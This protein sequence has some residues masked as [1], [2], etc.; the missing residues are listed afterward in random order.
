MSLQRVFALVMRYLYL[1][2]S[3]W[4]RLIELIYWPTMQMILWGF[5]N[6]F[7]V[8][9]SEWVAQAAGLLIGAVLLWD[10]LFRAQLGVSVV[11]FEEMYSRNLGHLF[12]SPL[13]PYELVMALLTV[14]FLRTSIGVGAA[15]GLA[16]VLYRYSIFDMG[17]PLVA[18]FANL[19]VMGWA[20]GL[21]VVALVLRYGL[22]AESLAWAVIFAVAP[23]SG[24]YY[25]ISV[26]PDWLQKIALLLPSSHVFEGM[27]AVV[28]EHVFSLDSFW[29]AVL[30]NLIYLL[31]GFALYLFAFHVARKRGLLLQMGE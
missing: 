14:S 2:R 26:L 19:L 21:M 20:I 11:F 9:H 25:P 22:G 13:R 27:R 8:G 3:S 16:V 18:F 6:Q 17:L 4:P 31:I 24:I 23:L 15:A 1:M 5:I 28:R 7:F 10:V 30:L 12:V 29:M